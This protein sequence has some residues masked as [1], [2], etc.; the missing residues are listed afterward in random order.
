[1][2]DMLLLQIP[3]D[4]N[5]CPLKGSRSRIFG[6][7]KSRCCTGMPWSFA[8]PLKLSASLFMWM[9]YFPAGECIFFDP[10][11]PAFSNA[12]LQNLSLVIN[13]TKHIQIKQSGIHEDV[14]PEEFAKYFPSFMW[15]VRDFT[16][17]LVDQEGEMISPKEYLEKALASQKGFSDAI[18]QKNRIRRLL[19]SFFHERDC[20]TMIRPLTNEEKLQN[21]I[22]IPL[23]ELRSEFVE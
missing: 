22:K 1:M 12:S 8:Q 21:L 23:E 17:Q 13:L 4:S 2:S 6:P 16:L 18:E 11:T 15:V 7:L 19:K 20:V 14:D 9:R 3:K 5:W 10:C